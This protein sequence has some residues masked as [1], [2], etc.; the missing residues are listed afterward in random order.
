MAFKANSKIL[1]EEKINC[2]TER[3]FFN[4]LK[5]LINFCIFMRILMIKFAHKI[6]FFTNETLKSELKMICKIK[7]KN[8]T[9]FGKSEN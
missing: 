4:F 3:S 2:I 6:I 1:E 5:P 8:I 7:S 9:V